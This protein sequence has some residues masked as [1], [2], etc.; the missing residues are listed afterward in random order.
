MEEKIKLSIACLTYNHE[1]YIAKTLESFLHQKVNFRY[2]ILIHDDASTDNTAEIIR[3]Y[4]RKYPEIIKPIYQEVNQYS[5]GITHATGAF[6]LPRARGEYIAMC[7]GDDYWIDDQKLQKQV[8]YLDLHPEVSFC[9]HAAKTE[10]VDASFTDREVRPYSSSRRL[11]P[12]EVIDK[13]SGYPMASLVFR[14]EYMK[15]MPDYYTSCPVGD[16]PMQL[17]LASH[18]EGYYMDEFMSVYRIGGA[19]SW[20]VRMKEGEYERKQEEYASRMEATYLEFDKETDHRYHEAVLSAIR[21]IR[22]LTYVN[23]RQY[24]YIFDRKY[25][26]YYKELNFRTV[27]L[28]RLQYRLPKFYEWLQKTFKKERTF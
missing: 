4:E 25:R 15:S 24:E 7:E 19:A 18:G 10:V 13:A 5:R 2:E 23:T 3:Q 6:N 27:A 26:K 11:S 8:D 14:R 12:Q 22:Y 9:I 1:E 28:M 16:I 21:R 17:I 20:S